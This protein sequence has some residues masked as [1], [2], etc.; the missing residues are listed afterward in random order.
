MFLFYS[1]KICEPQLICNQC[2]WFLSCEC[3]YFPLRYYLH[4]NL[5]VSPGIPWLIYCACSGCLLCLHFYEEQGNKNNN[6]NNNTISNLNNIINRS[7]KQNAVSS[8][9][10]CWNCC[11]FSCCNLCCK[12]CFCCLPC[13]NCC[14][15]NC[16][17]PFNLPE[18]KLP[19]KSTKTSKSK[20]SIEQL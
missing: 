20:E 4:A 16:L 8:F 13:I 2:C 14:N 15:A 5:L 12:C 17:K 18:L 11:C 7:A 10:Y 9:S 1:T 3:C 6:R 19:E